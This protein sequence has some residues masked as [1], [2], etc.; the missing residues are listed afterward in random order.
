MNMRET[1]AAIGTASGE[2][3]V[4]IVR[5]SGSLS[6]AIADRLFRCAPPLPS[7]RPGGTF[8]Y[9]GIGPPEACVDKGILLIFRAP[10]SYT[11]E[12]VIELQCHGGRESARR[13]LRAVLEAGARL[14]EPGEFTRRA[15]ENGRLD[16]AQAEAVMDLIAAQSDRAAASALEQLNGSLSV[17][18]SNIYDDIVMA[19]ADLEATL[20]FPEEDFP[21]ELVS[22]VITRVNNVLGRLE[23]LLST[24]EEGHRLREGALVVISGR[25]NAGKSTLLNR[26]LGKERAIVSPTPGTTRDAI[27]E[28]M[29]LNGMPLRLVDTAGLRETDCAI[30]QEGISRAHSYIKK[31]DLRIHVVDAS[32]PDSHA[33]HTSV[34][35][36]PPNRV[37]ILLNKQDIGHAVNPSDYNGYTTIEF[38]LATSRS[39]EPLLQAMTAK[40]DTH[41]LAPPHATL[42]ERHR[43]LSLHA[44]KCLSAALDIIQDP[45]GLVPAASNLRDAAEQIGR[46][47]GRTYY[48]DMLDRIFSRFCIGK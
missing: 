4:S 46:I 45:A 20:D 30:E 28:T 1:I 19:S 27:E 16:L 36:T 15:F 41:P 11:R 3:A 33:D 9:G 23:G 24:W 29:I 32:L 31:A 39:L 25:T 13:V 38:S 8:V 12:D 47:T 26:L 22:G 5:V 35:G 48:E 21:E 40:L 43:L 2:G 6:L 37:L 10:K 17:V 7:A 44:Q 42:S 18:L 34:A 14:A